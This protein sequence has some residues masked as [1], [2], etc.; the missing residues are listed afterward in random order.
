MKITRQ[1]VSI[2]DRYDASIPTLRKGGGSITSDN[3]AAGVVP[4]CEKV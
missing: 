1:A 3:P 4:P 2:H